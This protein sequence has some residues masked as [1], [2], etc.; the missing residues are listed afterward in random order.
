MQNV[1][2]IVLATASCLPLIAFA[3]EVTED[4]VLHAT[5]AAFQQPG[6]FSAEYIARQRQVLVMAAR[7]GN[8]IARLVIDK[9]GETIEQGA[10]K[11]WIP[12]VSQSP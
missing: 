5:F 1:I 12:Q 4:Q 3:T 6:V 2:R 7:E 9:Y 11:S 10:E 8:A